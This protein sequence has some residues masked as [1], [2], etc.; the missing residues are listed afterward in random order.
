MTQRIDA[1]FVA[2]GKYHDID[3][4]RLELLKLLAEHE[5][6]RTT[7]AMDYS[8]VDRIAAC[9]FLITYTCD[10]M[11]TPAETQAIKAF[12]EKG[13]RWLALHG[14]NSILRFVEGGVDC[15]EDRN[16]VM[17]ILGTQFKAH[18]PIGP[19]RVEVTD[20]THALTKGLEDFDIIDELYITKT[21]APIKVLM[22]TRFDGEATGFIEAKYDNAVV[23]ILY[24]RDHGKGAVLYNTL[25]HCR[26]HFDVIELMPFWAHPERC[27][28]NYPVYYE[29]LRRGIRWAIGEIV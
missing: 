4:A 1:H 5:N 28:W 3:F 9:Q 16:D 15:P 17:D 26:S 23:P 11:P 13:G 6:I 10:V 22:Q 24:L 21:T 20:R 18:P 25:G 14:T 12:L 8:N 27:G 2:A 7:V 29:T 19:F